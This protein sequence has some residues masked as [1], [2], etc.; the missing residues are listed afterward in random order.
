M[1]TIRV[2]AEQFRR[3][4]AHLLSRVSYSE[5][6]VIVDRHGAPQAVLIP[7]TL[8][9]KNKKNLARAPEHVPTETEF[10][11]SLVTKGVVRSPERIAADAATNPPRRLLQ[12][13]G[14]PTSEIIMEERR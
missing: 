12:S 8:Y 2:G 5:D 1:Q 3:D 7:Y 6:R 4:L 9:K 10:V 14:K 13:T 11:R